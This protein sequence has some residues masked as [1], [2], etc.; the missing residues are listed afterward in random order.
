MATPEIEPFELPVPTKVEL[1]PPLQAATAA[2]VS[3]DHGASLSQRA[4][5]DTSIE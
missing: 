1:E 3:D 4:R 2:T 5:I